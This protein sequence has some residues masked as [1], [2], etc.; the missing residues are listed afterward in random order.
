[1]G[2]QAG[3]RGYMAQTLVAIIDSLNEKIN[4]KTVTLESNEE[5][6]KVDIVWVFKDETKKVVQVKSTKN[7]F[8]YAKAVKWIAELK[9]KTLDASHYELFLVGDLQKKLKDNII[10]DKLNGAFVKKIPLS[11]NYFNSVITERIDIF[12]SSLNKPKVPHS[13]RSFIASNLKNEFIEN[14]IIGKELTP[15]RLKIELLKLFESFKEYLQASPY[16]LLIDS[17]KVNDNEIEE[18]HLL[19]HHFLELIGWKN[20]NYK[21]TCSEYNERTDEDDNYEVDYCG[22]KPSRL[23]SSET[24]Y[25]Y[26]KSKVV[27]NYDRIYEEKKMLKEFSLSFDKVSKSFEQDEFDNKS[28]TKRFFVNLFFSL[29]NEQNNEYIISEINKY[30]NNLNNNSIY[31]LLDNKQL[32]FIIRSIITAKSFRNDCAVKFLYPITEDNMKE[33]KIGKRDFYLPPQYLNSSI[34]PIVKENNGRISVL[35]F[36]NDTYNQTNLRKIIWL[37]VAITTGLANEYLIYFPDYSDKYKNEVFNVLR[38]F[39]D[40]LLIQKTK[41]YRL[42]NVTLNQLKTIPTSIKKTENFKNDI[43]NE[44][45]LEEINYKPNNDFLNNY[46]PYGSIIKPFLDS[47]EIDSD[48]LKD[49]LSKKGIL[50]KNKNKELIIDLMTNLLYS[51][52]EIQD[53]SN[54]IKNKKGKSKKIEKGSYIKSKDFNISSLENTINSALTTIKPIL[55]EIAKEK[56]AKISSI[57]PIS[58]NNTIEIIISY[59]EYNP[60]KQAM[61][62]RSTQFAKV[63]FKNSAKEIEPKQVFS[64]SLGRK[65]SKKVLSSIE[66]RLKRENKIVEITQDIKFSNFKSNEERIEF[67]FSFL[68]LDNSLIFTKANLKHSRYGFDEIQDIPKELHDKIGKKLRAKVSGNDIKDIR[69]FSD[70]DYRKFILLESVNISLEYDLQGAKGLL[71]VDI[72]FSGA[73]KNEFHPE[74]ILTFSTTSRPYSYHKKNKIQNLDNFNKKVDEVFSTF[75]KSKLK[76]FNLI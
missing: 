41:V 63:V 58:K 71:Y 8:S 46:L 53:L 48:D 51:P 54:S 14:S 12:L 72:D 4:W 6:E 47:Q 49:F 73:L 15:E 68:D 57:Q 36:C 66:D 56:N 33:D 67:L 3:L 32:N 50:F 1:M 39:K 38:E 21:Q 35:I 11:F 5:S 59:E 52:N 37:T 42:E 9:E 20:F 28:N 13:L 16:A 76:K 34:L 75:K 26:I 31:Y 18:R 55:K 29:D 64:N 60:N 24:D 43:V 74:G 17:E 30:Y 10:N 62:S 25:I 61:I 23:K 45:V 19:T 44:S 70:L 22:F 27:D 69:E 2:G 7:E 65:M 40:E